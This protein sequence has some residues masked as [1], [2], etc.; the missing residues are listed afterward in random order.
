MHKH[1]TADGRII[2]HTHPYNLKTDPDATKHHQSENEIHL[3]DVVFQGSFI[4]ASFTHYEQ[5]IIT[6][7][8]MVYL[9]YQAVGV[10]TSHFQYAYLRGPP[11]QLA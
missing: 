1:K 3:L 5:P 6:P 4:Q 8:C 2:I 9:V 11:S 7:I 10:Q